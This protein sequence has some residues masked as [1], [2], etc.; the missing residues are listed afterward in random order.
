MEFS[1]RQIAEVLH[2]KVEGNP[3]VKISNLGKIE[4]GT[5]G[6]M[7]FLA[8]PAYTHYIY[9]T[10]A[11]IIVVNDD[12][13]PSQRIN[14]TLIRVNNAYTAFA[15][16]IEIFNKRPQEKHGISSLSY[17]SK[18]AKLGEDVYVGEFTSIGE[19]VII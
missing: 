16:L 15:K 6:T 12:F 1:A 4:E 5:Q 10:K 3:D 17:I 14:G 11:S 19:N 7:T 8:N 2:G 9:S 13:I 18:S